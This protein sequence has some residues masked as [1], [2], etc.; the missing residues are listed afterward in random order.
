MTTKVRMVK[1]RMRRRMRKKR[2]KKKGRKI[3]LRVMRV[4]KK[5]FPTVC[6]RYTRRLPV[7]TA[8]RKVVVEVEVRVAILR[9]L[10]L[11]LRLVEVEL[12]QWREWDQGRHMM[13]AKERRFP[14]GLCRLR[15]W[16]S[17]FATVWG[18]SAG[19]I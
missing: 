7:A 9:R 10:P 13:A 19:L 11:R 2:K 15:R 5:I 14:P 1:E 8:L 17:C 16:T 18:A 12:Q 4:R 6:Y 3:V